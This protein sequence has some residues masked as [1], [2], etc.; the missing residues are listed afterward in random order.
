MPNSNNTPDLQ[1]KDLPD[2]VVAELE[3]TVGIGTPLQPA[4]EDGRTLFDTPGSK[5]GTIVTVFPQERFEKWRSQA[6]V[7]IRSIDERVYLAQVANGPYAAP[8]G[9]PATS[10]LLVTTQIEGTLFT[11]PYHGWVE[12]AILGEV[13]DE[14]VIAPL[15]RPRPNSPVKL[16]ALEETRNALKCD[17]DLRLGRAVG[18]PDLFVGL[19]SDEKHHIPRHT[20]VVG[21]TGAGKS[22]CMAGLIEKLSAAGFRRRGRIHDH[23]RARRLDQ[24]HPGAHIAG[25]EARRPTRHV[26]SRPDEHN[27]CQPSTPADSPLLP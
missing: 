19:R 25:S 7:H 1:P 15:Y 4:D 9:L 11:L 16:L 10:P 14:N 2:S 13:K 21:T 24:D 12:L 5:D 26:P 17:G 18:Y 20:L 23:Q 22:T 3:S 27:D 6:L 8:N